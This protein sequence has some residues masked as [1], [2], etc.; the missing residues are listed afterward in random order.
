MSEDA[1]GTFTRRGDNLDLRFER[2]YPR[3]SRR[4]GPP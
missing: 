4:F 3:P 2:V 1:L